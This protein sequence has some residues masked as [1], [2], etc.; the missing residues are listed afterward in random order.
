MARV[1]LTPVN[2]AGTAGLTL[3]TTGAQ[4]LATFTGVNFTNNG[5]VFLVVYIG[6]AGTC[7]MST[8]IGRQV[9][10]QAYP[11][12]TLTKTLANST[13]YLFGPWSAADFTQPDG[14]G[15]MWIDFSVVTGN[16][17]TLYQLVPTP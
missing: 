15:L 7:T 16:S 6:V 3:P 10:G 12:A 5:Q 9:Q 8:W 13:N 11:V 1:T 2:L 14:T 17:V 4:T